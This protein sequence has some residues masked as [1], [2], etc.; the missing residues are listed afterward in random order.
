MEAKDAMKLAIELHEGQVRKFSGVPYVT[1][2]IQ[3]GEMLA[4]M[5]APEYVVVAG[6]LHDT[7]EDTEATPEFLLAR[8]VREES[9]ALIKEVSRD[10]NETYGEFIERIC[11]AEDPWAPILKRADVLSNLSTL[12]HGDKKEK[13]YRRALDTLNGVIVNR[14]TK[15][16]AILG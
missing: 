9:I 5:G 1:H 12:P 14:L 10:E 7:L 8:G 11:Y 13:R 2:P 15:R 6:F 16:P 4:F 3:V